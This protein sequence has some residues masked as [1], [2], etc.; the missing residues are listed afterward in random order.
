MKLF[1]RLLTPLVALIA[2]AGSASAPAEQAAPVAAAPA[3]QAHPAL[4][5]IADHDTTIYLFGT[6]HLLPA[7]IDWLNGPLADALD[8]SDTLMTD[9]PPGDIDRKSVV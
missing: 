7:G 9:L 4:W 3:V 5:K 2:L 8:H 6:I 1:K